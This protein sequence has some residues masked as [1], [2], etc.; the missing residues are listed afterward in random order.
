MKNLYCIEYTN[1]I[2]SDGFIYK[3]RANNVNE[4]IGNFFINMNGEDNIAQTAIQAME[5]PD[6]A[7]ALF[8]RLDH[9]NNQIRNIFTIGNWI[10]CTEEEDEY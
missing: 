4:A 7:I 3:T 6:K 2:F 1:D 9:N 5:T 8:E 10:Y